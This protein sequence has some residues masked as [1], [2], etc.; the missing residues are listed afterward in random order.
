MNP[1]TMGKHHS[2][3]TTHRSAVDVSTPCR[4]DSRRR[5]DAGQKGAEGDVTEQSREGQAGD[6][7]G[8][9]GPARESEHL[10]DEDQ[11]RADVAP[12]NQGEG[13]RPRRKG[14]KKFERPALHAGMAG[15]DKVGGKVTQ[16]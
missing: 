13:P 14:P 7:L 16:R 12:G 5:S 10:G 3:L 9:G 15:V 6:E 11:G 1:Q 4:T 2:D 8:T